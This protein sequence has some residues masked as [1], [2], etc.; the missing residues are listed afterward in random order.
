MS[1]KKNPQEAAATEEVAAA[2]AMSAESVIATL[3]EKLAAAEKAV[4]KALTEKAAL[5][6]AFDQYKEDAKAILAEAGKSRIVTS[7][8]PVLEHE[9]ELYVFQMGVLHIGGKKILAADVIANP[10]A[11][12]SEIETL[13]R[14]KI[15]KPFKAE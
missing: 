12:E 11:F 14:L 6:A 5:Q 7:D 10:A 4:A 1:G 2:N 8:R 15:L 3:E 13:L 9:G